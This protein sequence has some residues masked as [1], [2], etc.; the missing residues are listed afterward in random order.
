MTVT[1]PANPIAA[2]STYTLT[3]RYQIDPLAVYQQLC[4]NKSNTV[5]LESAEIDQ[6]HQLKK[7]IIS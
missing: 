6:K 2:V 1:T 4:G 5:L 7:P 3:G